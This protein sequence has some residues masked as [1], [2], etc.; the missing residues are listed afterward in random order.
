MA[1][2]EYG[3]VMQ[4]FLFWLEVL[5]SVD[6][7]VVLETLVTNDFEDLHHSEMSR[8]VQVV[9]YRLWAVLTP[10]QLTEAIQQVYI[11]LSDNAVD[12]DDIRRKRKVD[13]DIAVPLHLQKIRSKL[14]LLKLVRLYNSSG[15]GPTI[16]DFSS[17]PSTTWD[18]D[19]PQTFIEHFNMNLQFSRGWYHDRAALSDLYTLQTNPENYVRLNATGTPV[20]FPVDQLRKTGIIRAF[21]LGGANF[22]ENSASELT[23]YFLPQ[24]SPTTAELQA[25]YERCLAAIGSFVSLRNK[26]REELIQSATTTDPNMFKDPHEFSAITAMHSGELSRDL[27][28]LRLGALSGIYTTTQELHD[29]NAVRLRHLQRTGNVKGTY[30][31]FAD[32]ANSIHLVFSGDPIHGIPLALSDLYKENRA[33]GELMRSD[34]VWVRKANAIFYKGNVAT[35][36]YTG[37]SHMINKLT[38][39][40]RENLLLMPQQQSVFLLMVLWHMLAT[41]HLTVTGTIIVLCGRPETGKSHALNMLAECVARCLIIR[42]GSSS[43]L[44]GTD[45]NHDSDLRIKITDENRSTRTDAK[46]SS[47]GT[48][49]LNDQ[50][51]YGEGVIYHRRL[52]R[53][54]STGVYSTQNTITAARQMDFSG[55]NMPQNIPSAKASRSCIIPVT[56]L[57]SGTSQLRSGAIASAMSSDIM[58][59]EDAHACKLALKMVS[60]LQIRTTAL[61]AFGGLPPLDTTCVRIFIAV[62]EK[63]LGVD[64]MQ[65]RRKND[66]IRLARAIKVWNDTTMWH[67]RGLGDRFDYDITVEYMFLASRQYIRMEEVIVAYVMLEQTRSMQAYIAEIMMTLKTSVQIIDGEMGQTDHYYFSAYSREHDLLAYIDRRHPQFGDGITAK[68]YNTMRMGCTNKMPNIDKVKNR[69]GV[70][71]IAFNKEWLGSVNTPVEDGILVCLQRLIDEKSPFVTRDYETEESYVFS[72]R[73]RN[74]LYNPASAD[75]MHFPEL[76]G[77]TKDSIRHACAMLES[78]RLDD[79]APLFNRNLQTCDGLK[80]VDAGFPGSVPSIRYTGRHKVSKA[81]SAPLIVNPSLFDVKT[82]NSINED[83]IKTVLIIAG[84]YDNGKRIFAGMDPSRPVDDL[85]DNFVRVDEGEEATITLKN[86]YYRHD[87]MD[88]VVYGGVEGLGLATSPELFPE[89]EKEVTFTQDSNIEKIVRDKALAQVPLSDEMS[90]AFNDAL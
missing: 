29:R 89:G 56:T 68:C 36:G 39:L 55:T 23:L 41:S 81:V 75:A 67:C 60:S 87:S 10:T 37:L 73:V 47:S 35:R 28:S 14:H 59:A 85:V 32:M 33:L 80:L 18:E 58:V 83:L 69:E 72:A 43:E 21:Q 25:K 45:G 3:L 65:T 11:C 52:L 38:I 90:S 76:R 64:A 2:E 50:S 82:P 48:K 42:E 86:M 79:G 84:G 70:E 12:S 26:T 6:A 54:P 8:L 66:L 13:D 71:Q 15:R 49:D 7:Y 34:E 20:F 74:S 51:A 5:R 30:K 62:L 53:N 27:D 31:F 57:N 44:A 63:M 22:L 9:G 24:F 40:S 46:D 17:A 1:L 4:L 88:G 19:E 77:E 78:R 61:E 16:T